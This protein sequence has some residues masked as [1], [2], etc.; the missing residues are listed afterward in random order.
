[1]KIGILGP[2]N[3]GGALG[4]QWAKAGHAVFFGS[5]YP[6]ELQSLVKEA[7]NGVRRGTLEEA[8]GFGEV[9]VFA[10]PWWKKEGLPQPDQFKGKVV[11]DATNPYSALISGDGKSFRVKDMG[12]ATSSED[13]A[14]LLPAARLVKAF[15]TIAPADLKSEAFKSGGDRLAIFVAGDDLGAKHVVSGLIR[16]IGFVPVDTGSLR[17]GGRLQKLGSPIHTKRLTEEQAV[18]ALQSLKT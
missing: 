9:A 1:L 7:A 2:G 17:E 15:N 8:A 10:I 6:D 3:I 5:R 11:V 14:K 16:D 4:H 12:D 13:V 18:T